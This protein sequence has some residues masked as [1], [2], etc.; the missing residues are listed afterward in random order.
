MFNCEKQKKKKNFNC[1]I[2]CDMNT[3]FIIYFDMLIILKFNEN[4]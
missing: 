4:L 1:D 3:I 2:F